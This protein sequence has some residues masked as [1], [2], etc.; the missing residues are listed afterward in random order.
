VSTIAPARASSKV[1]EWVE[2]DA[3]VEDNHDDEAPLGRLRPCP[4]EPP[5]DKGAFEL[6]A[7]ELEEAAAG[8]ASP[9]KAMRHPA[10]VEILALGFKTVPWIIDRLEQDKYR[11]LWMR[12]LGSLTGS[13]PSGGANTVPAAAEVWMRWGR[14]DAR[15]VGRH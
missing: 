8:L 7:D 2:D 14:H 13:P 12:V 11:P 3:I 5:N 4:D 15:L 1:W 10:Y 9:R 6:L